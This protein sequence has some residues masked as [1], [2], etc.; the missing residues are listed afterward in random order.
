MLLNCGGGK[1]SWESLGLHGDQTIQ[2][3]RK[4][5]LNIHWKDWCWSSNTLAIW[6]KELTHWKRLWCWERLKAGE[7]DDRGWGGW[8]AS[9]ILS[10]YEFEQAAEDEGQGSLACR[11]P[12]G[13][14]ESDTTERL[15]K[16]QNPTI[17]CSQKNV[18]NYIEMLKVKKI[19]NKMYHANQ[20]KTGINY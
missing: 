19:W 9:R 2:S 1:N 18:L 8:V 15:D 5:S 12:W 3:K 4:S 14:K 17:F 16:K 11:S 13:G 20:N 10:E 6:C 7:G